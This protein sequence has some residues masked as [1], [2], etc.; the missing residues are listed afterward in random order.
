MLTEDLSFSLDTKP[1]LF[2]HRL[3]KTLGIPI[4]MNS[5]V[6]QRE[7][8]NEVTDALVGSSRSGILTASRAEIDTQV[9]YPAK[10]SKRRP[11]KWL[12]PRDER[13]PNFDFSSGHHEIHHDA[14]N[15]S[16]VD[17]G[18]VMKFSRFG[19][20]IFDA[21]QDF[22]QETSTPFS[23]LFG[24]YDTKVGEIL[25]NSVQVQGPALVLIDAIWSDNF[26]HW[27]I[28]TLPKLSCMRGFRDCKIITKSNLKKWQYEILSLAGISL[29]NLVQLD[30]FQACRAEHLIIPS[31][32]TQLKH[33]LFGCHP[34]IVAFMRSM[35]GPLMAIEK[36]HKSPVLD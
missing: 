4:Q 7:F 25:S 11:P 19:P 8:V 24:L 31:N 14:Y 15:Y 20:I 27:L 26:S 10:R 29:S 2:L 5:V 22:F 9:L 21:N 6:E 1:S 32:I 13:F 16:V 17:A 12:G 30:D 34:D 3:S 35:L 18:Y 36:F 28:D 33:P 23:Q